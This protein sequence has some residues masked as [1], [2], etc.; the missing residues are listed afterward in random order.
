MNSR[1]M[2]SMMICISLTKYG[3]AMRAATSTDRQK[4]AGGSFQRFAVKSRRGDS[5]KQGQH[6][7]S[8]IMATAIRFKANEASGHPR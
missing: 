8:A 6:P 7:T 5:G 3:A 4:A 1:F 2:W